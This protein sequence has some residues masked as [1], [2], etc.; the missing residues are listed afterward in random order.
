MAAAANMNPQRDAENQRLESKREFR[1]GASLLDMATT[2]FVEMRCEKGKP[3]RS[4][5]CRAASGAGLY[6]STER[7][8]REISKSEI[9]NSKSE[10]N[11]NDQN[12]NDQNEDGRRTRSRFEH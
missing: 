8:S 2:P 5:C 4:R 12:P 3:A 10:T 11:S 1:R 6:L 9:Q 7:G